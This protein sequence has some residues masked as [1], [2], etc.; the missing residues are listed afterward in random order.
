MSVFPK[1]AEVDDLVADGHID[2]LSKTGSPA[3]VHV[4]VGRPRP[5]SD[6]PK[7]DWFCPIWMEGLTQGVK[8]FGGVGPIDS[9]MNAMDWVRSRYREIAVTEPER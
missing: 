7:D 5:V 3:R 6:D 1:L 2:Y 8:C 9:L 4:K